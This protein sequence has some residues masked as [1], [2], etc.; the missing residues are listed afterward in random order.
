[1]SPKLSR[2]LVVAAVAAGFGVLPM[3]AAFADS[4]VDVYNPPTGFSNHA[5]VSGDCHDSNPGD[6]PKTNIPIGAS[7]NWYIKEGKHNVTPA[8]DVPGGQRWGQKG[9]GDLTPADDPF[10]AKFTKAGLYFYFSSTG[11]EG[12]DSKGV[13][14][15]MCGVINVVDPNA[16]TTTTATPPTTAPPD[17]PPPTTPTT[18][19]HP[20]PGPSVTTAPPAAPG[21]VPTTAAPAPT[22][23]TAK[24]GKSKDS[25][26]TSTTTTT[27]PP[28][29]NLPADAIVPDVTGGTAVQNGVE[30]PTSTPQGDAVALIKKNHSDNALKGLIVTGVGIAGLGIGTGAYK[31]AHRSSKYF[32]A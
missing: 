1:M 31:F 5:N 9:S 27:A 18:A 24:A 2:L 25:T 23:T 3:Q 8:E 21:H 19:P 32:P 20:G 7:V 22:T 12:S 14:S 17:D 30:A 28:P 16:T 29:I 15:G 11:G 26:T 13:L 10:T 4:G 6:I